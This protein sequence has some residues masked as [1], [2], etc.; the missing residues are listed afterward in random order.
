MNKKGFRADSW[1]N[2]SYNK[3]HGAASAQGVDV[4]HKRVDAAFSPSNYFVPGWRGDSLPSKSSVILSHAIMDLWQEAK[5]QLSTIKRPT[6]S[7][8]AMV[9]EEFLLYCA[10]RELSLSGL[11]S[12]TEF[13]QHLHDEDSSHSK[14]L[15]NF[16]DIYC[17][18]AVTVYLFKIRFLNILM[19][20]IKQNFSVAHMANPSNLISKL[21][22]VGSS[23]ELICDSFRPNCYS[24]FR[25]C[26]E[27]DKLSLEKLKQVLQ[28][29]HITEMVKM[30]SFKV[31]AGESF[32][33]FFKDEK[34]FEDAPYSHSLSHRAFGRFINL[35]LIYMPQWL[36]E[37]A[38][39]CPP[40]KPNSL[41][42]LKTK[43]AGD[44]LSSLCL[45]HWL[46]Q[47][48]FVH[49]NW[50][51]IICPDFV[52][53]D[54]TD[55]S[56]VKIC[57]EL[58]FLTFMVKVA[59]EQDFSVL[60]LIAK[61]MREKNEKGTNSAGQFALFGSDRSI[62]NNNYK[63]IV[64]NLTKQPKKNPH[65]HLISRIREQM[66]DLDRDGW[67]F[68]LTTQKLFVPS[69]TD[70]LQQLLG[71][72][73]VHAGISLE[74]IKGKGEIPHYLYVFSHRDAKKHPAGARESYQHFQW[75]G[76]LN[77]F[78]RFSWFPEEFEKFV[79]SRSAYAT[80]L[81]QSESEGRQFNFH[82]D[83]LFEGKLLTS[84]NEDHSRITHPAFFKKLT[85]GCVPLD[86]FFL[87]DSL[88]DQSISEKVPQQDILGMLF[89]PRQHHPYVLVVDTRQPSHVGL[90]LISS[91]AYKA[92]R[93]QYG[94]A[95]FHYFGLMPKMADINP[96]LFRIFF[97]S[98]LGQ[99]LVQL[100]LGGSTVNLKS[101]LNSTLIPGFFAFPRFFPTDAMSV[102]GVLE[103]SSETILA[104][105]PKEMDE[106][107][108]MAKKLVSDSALSYG[109]HALSLLAAFKIQLAS[110]TQG[111]ERTPR[112]IVNYHNPLILEPLL[113]LP[114]TPLLPH[115]EDLFVKVLTG[116]RKAL[117]SPI[118]RVSSHK[119]ADGST[120]LE[121]MQNEVCIV[122]LHG[123]EDFLHF[124]KFVVTGSLC[125]PLSTILHGLQLPRSAELSKVVS[126][127]RNLSTTVA[128]LA[129]KTDQLIEKVL[130]THLSRA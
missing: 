23:T 31:V 50:E 68:V 79:F 33:D 117:N 2:P 99:Q 110:A 72:A 4:S 106:K 115:H 109:W 103:Q 20:Q 105:H 3:T 34:I 107:F 93:E 108:E 92:K 81:Y 87:L 65:Q 61:T 67:L 47:E 8:A 54:F 27:K 111:L 95:Y 42:A 15:E 26:S 29:T 102:A 16:R 125:A 18:R 98:A 57:H 36:E 77:M 53:K 73:K 40:T 17:F 128:S 82:Q 51:E 122:E 120:Y 48:E 44:Q 74:N 46:A 25:P 13:W 85:G 59:K 64:L 89:K 32:D 56:F 11:D 113:N 35:N 112:D 94:N 88:N 126:G 124:V 43:F 24:W 104:T 119:S 123:D 130:H 86:Q 41:Q 58:Q 78:S 114:S 97:Q 12:V 63:R 121:L 7:L 21:F 76:E 75:E 37:R 6:R 39:Q 66:K 5:R 83:A 9:H 14:E 96:N 55:G 118:D 19:E 49:Q 71:L 30:C 84:A 90:E 101:K 45:S 60:Q 38:H 22:R 10:S 1:L 129:S 28:S 62:G 127:Y 70:K 52:G 80:P 91:E 100:S 69:R 116:D